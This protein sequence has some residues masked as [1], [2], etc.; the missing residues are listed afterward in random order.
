MPTVGRE[1]LIDALLSH[2]HARQDGQ[3]FAAIDVHLAP[4]PGEG[5]NWDVVVDGAEPADVAQA[6]RKLFDYELS[7][8]QDGK[9]FSAPS[10]RR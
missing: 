8:E 5:P 4:R 3:A 9:T 2:L 1:A 10:P 6:K 7:A